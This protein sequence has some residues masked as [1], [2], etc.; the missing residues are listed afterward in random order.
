MGT[1][2]ETANVDYRI[3]FCRSRRKTVTSVFHIYGYILKYWNGSIY[4][5]WI[6]IYIYIHIYNIIYRYLYQYIYIYIYDNVSN[7]KMENGRPGD[8]SLILL[9]FAHCANG[10]LSFVHLL[11]KKQTEV[12][13]CKR[14]KRTKR[15]CPYMR[16]EHQRLSPRAQCYGVS[17][18]SPF[19]LCFHPLVFFISKSVVFYKIF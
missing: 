3:S 17:A 12:I 2:V 9:P 13:R 11:K 16:N 4:I 14:T 8:F 18:F 5:L 7:G 1:Y 15:T 6:N 10:S 19:L